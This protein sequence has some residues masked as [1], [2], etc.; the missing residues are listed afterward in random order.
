MFDDL[1]AQVSS[2]FIAGPPAVQAYPNAGH[3]SPMITT[4]PPAQVTMGPIAATPALDL[5]FD[6]SLISPHPVTQSP[7]TPTTPQKTADNSAANTYVPFETFVSITRTLLIYLFVTGA[8]SPATPVKS[9]SPASS[10]SKDTR[11]KAIPLKPQRRSSAA[12]N[13]SA[14]GPEQILPFDASNT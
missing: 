12:L 4:I 7:G 5:K 14:K 10:P 2:D 1:D 6:A 3:T 13:R 11:E 8:H 9:P